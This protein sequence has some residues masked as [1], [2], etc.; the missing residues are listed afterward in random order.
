MVGTF[1]RECLDDMI[2][3]G[4]I[5]LGRILKEYGAHYVCGMPH[6][7]FGLEM[8]AGS[9]FPVVPLIRVGIVARPVL[10][11][12]HDEYERGAA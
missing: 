5:H 11:D 7:T 6:R 3:I 2:V 12:L 8:P 9:S 10:G 1:R 4:R